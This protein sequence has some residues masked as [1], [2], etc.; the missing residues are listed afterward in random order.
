M[1]HQHVSTKPETHKSTGHDFSIGNFVGPYK[2]TDVICRRSDVLVLRVEDTRSDEVS[3]NLALKILPQAGAHRVYF[4]SLGYEFQ[5]LQKIK[6]PGIVQVFDC[7]ELPDSRFACMVMEYVDGLSIDRYLR[8]NLPGDQTQAHRLLIDLCVQCAQIG[9]Y[10]ARRSMIQTDPKCD[11]FIVTQQGAV[12]FVKLIDF[13]HALDLAELATRRGAANWSA[14][15]II[16]AEI[17]ALVNNLLDMFE[18]VPGL[19]VLAPE[20]F[21]QTLLDCRSFEALIFALQ[22]NI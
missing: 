22:S 4:G 5:F 1:L 18:H 3:E 2:V 7:F 16:A 11:H 14:E 21:R 19:R 13:G 17:S 15:N 12:P 6:H 10:L 20:N 8:A 9:Q